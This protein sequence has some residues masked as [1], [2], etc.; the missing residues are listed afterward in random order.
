MSRC[1]TRVSVTLSLSRDSLSLETLSLSRLSLSLSLAIQ[2]D[3]SLSLSLS[4]DSL[5]RLSL[6]LCDRCTFRCFLLFLFPYEHVF[7][8]SLYFSSV[9]SQSPPQWRS[10][11]GRTAAKRFRRVGVGNVDREAPADSCLSSP[12]SQQLS[13]APGFFAFLPQKGVSVCPVS[14]V[15][16]Q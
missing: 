9:R 1:G 11:Q 14:R 15:C 3:V 5:S 13:A 8:H 16:V 12:T 2:L 4:R 10:P 6:C 7:T